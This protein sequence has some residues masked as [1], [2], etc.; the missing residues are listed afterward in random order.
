M[1]KCSKPPQALERLGVADH[2][3]FQWY[4]GLLRFTLTYGWVTTIDLDAHVYFAMFFIPLCPRG[5]TYCPR[6]TRAALALNARVQGEPRKPSRMALGAHRDRYL[7]IL[8]PHNGHFW[9]GRVAITEASPGPISV[10][11]AQ[12]PTRVGSHGKNR[13][14]QRA[15]LGSRMPKFEARVTAD[16]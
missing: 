16:A 12:R 4:V 8:V 7:S 3:S 15:P 14:S 5:Y 10:S 11:R 13:D 9:L 6:A 1:A 2:C